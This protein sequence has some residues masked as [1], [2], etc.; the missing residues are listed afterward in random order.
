MT[1]RFRIRTPAGQEVS[2]ATKEMFEDFV[3]SGD[4]SPDDLVYDRETGSWSSARTHPAVIDIQY[5]EPEADA[6][7]EQARQ[8][9]T[10][11][12][13][14][15]SAAQ[16]QE[17]AAQPQE[18]APQPQES[19]PQEDDATQEEAVAA[20]ADAPDEGDAHPEEGSTAGSEVDLDLDLELTEEMSPEESKRIFLE[21]LEAER[22]ADIDAGD[23]IVDNLSG[24]TIDSESMGQGLQDRPP[25]SAEQRRQEQGAS[26]ARRGGGEPSR[27]RSE[28]DRRNASSKGRQP[29]HRKAPGGRDQPDRRTEQAR[30][31]SAK[32][33]GLGRVVRM[34]VLLLLLAAGGFVAYELLLDGS[35]SSEDGPG[36]EAEAAEVEQPPAPDASAPDEGAPDGD[37]EAPGADEGVPSGDEGAP[38]AGEGEAAEPTPSVP[39]TES[40]IR[41]RAQE[42]YLAATQ[43]ALRDLEPIPDVW[44]TGPYLSVPSDHPEVVDAWH[45]YLSTIQA[46]RP[47]D[48]ERYRV[49]Y[50]ATLDDAAVTGE[51][52]QERLERALADFAETDALRQG[53]FDRVEALAR[54]ALQS[55]NALVE[56]EGTI[57][58]DATESTGRQQTV[59]RGTSARDAESRLVL[60][61]VVEL[62]EGA[63]DAD[64][65]GPGSG[66]NVR[67]WVW[68]GFLD[69]A[70]R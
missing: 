62:L 23:S 17:S 36:A 31:A 52:R 15:E 64:G 40:A 5:E 32:G 2:F 26:D 30:T 42:R 3:R 13:P 63:L 35:D 28:T 68:D 65:E 24:F 55:H 69:V 38:S 48:E 37:E 39:D 50:E 56:V 21:Q 66:E 47:G 67:A 9:D 57:L 10:P 8:K 46:V 1:A 16:P 19:A 18:S 60:G 7:K 58:Y 53:H 25:A 59:G 6:Q 12:E 43:R 41:G 20:S 61:Q 34:L 49:A 11:Q 54:A 22:Q 51:A 27:R 33:G 29:D 4:L 45:G 44:P 70:T 14:Q